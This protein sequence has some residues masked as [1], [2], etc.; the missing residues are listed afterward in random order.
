[1]G[2]A[3]PAH[4]QFHPE[5]ACL[6]VP[7]LAQNAILRHALLDAL[8]DSRARVVWISAPP[9]YGKT[10]L[11]AQHAELTQS[12][13]QSVSWLSVQSVDADAHRLGA[14][15]R[16]ALACAASA[17]SR[18]TESW[19]ATHPELHLTEAL[20]A[21]AANG[22]PQTLY[23]DDCHLAASPDSCALIG[24]LLRRTPPNL[25]I[26]ATVHGQPAIPLVELELQGL[27]RRLGESDMR[28][29][30]VEAQEYLGSSVTP[31]ALAAVL[32][33][34]RGWPIALQ[35]ARSLSSKVAPP[36]FEPEMLSGTD[37]MLGRY[38]NEL[39]LSHVPAALK[40]FLTDTAVLDRVNGDIADAIRESS[41]GWSLLEEVEARGL[42]IAPC[43]AEGEWFQ[44]HPIFREFLAHRGRRADPQ[45]EKSL[46]RRAALWLARHE[47]WP[48]AIQQAM[49]SGDIEL[50]AQI[51]DRTNH[52]E[53][54]MRFG[55][56]VLG[57]LDQLPDERLAR[58]PRLALCVAYAH[59]QE[60]RIA[61]VR[62]LLDAIPPPQ[63]PENGSGDRTEVAQRDVFEALVAM[64]EDRAYP[65]LMERIEAHLARSEVDDPVV[66][67][68][69][70]IVRI[71][72]CQN[73]DDPAGALLLSDRLIQE[74]QNVHTPYL[75]GFGWVV[76][77]MAHMA[78]AEL[79]AAQQ[80]YEQ[81]LQLGEKYFGRAAAHTP[82]AEITLAEVLFERNRFAEAIIPLERGLLRF[83]SIYGWYELWE[84]AILAAP[85][86]L[87]HV[88]GVDRALTFLNQSQSNAQ[89]RGLERAT[90]LCEAARVS[91]LLR[92]GQP[93][94]ALRVF[95]R[96]Q[97]PGLLRQPPDIR[98]ARVFTHALVVAHD[99]AVARGEAGRWSEVMGT[100]I[101][102]LRQ[103][104]LRRRLLLA[105]LAHASSAEHVGDENAA[106]SSL[107][108]ALLLGAHRGFV[109]VF[110]E[111]AQALQAT[112]ARIGTESFDASS[113]AE[114]RTM[115]ASMR[116]RGGLG[117]APLEA[118]LLSPREAQVLRMMPEGLTSKEI[119]QRLG[120]THNTVKGYRRT[121]FEK[122]GVT[123][124]SQAIEKARLLQ[125]L[126]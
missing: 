83:D 37:A 12:R 1:M 44:Y 19:H 18:P 90:I 76:R 104:G 103:R 2:P 13:G 24:T 14:H 69:C 100:H 87:A 45:R 36:E 120:V 75:D 23:L 113:Q 93:D 63:P 105:L 47:T 112:V 17:R 118:A 85:P 96:S 31:A 121:L 109:R 32:E 26:V 25:R 46:R 68:Q 53:V 48:E 107:R 10:F 30:Y 61:H 57:G 7:P 125:L 110:L 66:R 89:T 62:R 60:G 20:S 115:I 101:S 114:V 97:L 82:I 126:S 28:F 65:D 94:D 38:F 50:A 9:G 102:Y 119:A 21:I 80:C 22:K 58:Y 15:L 64:C 27:L 111:R 106:A 98:T 67:G 78:R 70:Y 95:D 34:S 81:C 73:R 35:L 49:R 54:M 55:G 122:L 3:V 33:K 84:P 41:D 42:F 74:M 123:S 16:L 71:V 88:H 4:D 6:N 51:V 5:W 124:R 11:L 79:G 77:G 59:F 117:K 8:S 43:D 56:A 91:V 52:L 39:V 86:V 99:L 92:A 108:E 72:D 116:G 40:E 29:T